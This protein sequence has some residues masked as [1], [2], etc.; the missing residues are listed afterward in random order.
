MI[1]SL[2]TGDDTPSDADYYVAQY[3]G[4]GTTTTTYHRRPISALWN[5]IKSKLATVATSGSY[6]DLSNKPTIGNGTVTIKQAGTSKGTFTM[7]QSGNTTIELTDN[8]TTYGVATQSANGLESAA[9]KKKLDGIATGAEVN[10]NAFS[11][12]VV[13]STTISADSKTDSLTLAGSNVTLTPDTTNDKVTI[14]ITKA[15]V[16]SA[17]G[18]TP[19]T[20]NTTYGVA[21]SS[22]LGLVKSGT[23]ITVDSSGNVSVNDDS[24]NHV[25]SNVDGLQTALD[26]KANTSHGTHVSYGTFASA[27][28]TSS[29]G[30]A[31]TVSRSDHVHA[32]PALTSCTGTLSV[33]KGGTGATNAATART[34]LGI[35]PANIGAAA[36]SHTHS[37]A[38]V[39]NLQTTLDSKAVKKEL[40]SENLNDIKTPGFYNAGGSNSV[41]NKPSGVD[42]F[43]LYVVKRASGDYYTQILID[44][45]K[46]QYRRHC[47]NGTWGSWVEDKLTDTNTTYSAA[48]TSASGL[49]TAAM[50][51]KLNGITDSA[52]SV[53]FTRSLTSGTKIGTI[54]INGTGTDLY[55]NSQRS[56]TSS[57]TSTSTTTCL[58]ASAGKSL[59]DQITELN[60]NYATKSVSS[61]SIT[62]SA[63]T[64]ILNV[65]L[66]AGIYLIVAK[67]MYP[68]NATGQRYCYVGE[69][70]GGVSLMSISQP[71]SSYGNTI[72]QNS[73][74]YELTDDSTIN[75]YG[76]QNSGGTL[77]GCSGNLYYIKLN[78]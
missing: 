54:T 62:H 51:T 78:K 16:T 15:N 29:A 2:S 64:K 56:I 71:G 20:T 18:Y 31:T 58:S 59:Q 63:W 34:N 27:L 75:V 77:S 53:S 55:C 12:V 72:V 57:L 35:T 68:T 37:I 73:F 44:N 45:N 41:T 50:V 47:E 7:N 66:S 76:F 19:P 22:T 69:G 60:S 46:K 49:M 14:G 74:I 43:G 21:T 32:L 52:D 23:D 26:G 61:I 33:A 39:T 30:S 4:G 17:L 38:N 28:G 11:N 48:T 25:I 3:A 1:N 5:Y 6:N 24:H 36:S 10:Q 8:N 70:T 13:G 9:D 67:I 42:H 65:S 40:T